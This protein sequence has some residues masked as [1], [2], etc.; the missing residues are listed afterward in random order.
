MIIVNVKLQCHHYPIKGTLHG[1]K[2]LKN[3]NTFHLIVIIIV[4]VITVH[5]LKILDTFLSLSVIENQR[6]TPTG[7][8]E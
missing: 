5:Q 7:C 4:T 2:I 6:E 8:G 1:V 3:S